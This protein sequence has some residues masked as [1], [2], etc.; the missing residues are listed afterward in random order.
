MRTEKG[1]YYPIV[2]IEEEDT[3][4]VEQVYDDD[5]AMITVNNQLFRLG[6]SLEGPNCY[7]W[8]PRELRADTQEIWNQIR[9]AI[10]NNVNKG[11]NKQ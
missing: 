7:I 4:T 11:S 3:I 2:I 6:I 5:S 1:L 9:S 8:E 10:L